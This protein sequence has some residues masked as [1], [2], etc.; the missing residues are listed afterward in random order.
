MP[1]FKTSIIDIKEV[2]MA[3][4]L[5]LFT[6]G[7]KITANDTN[8]NNRYLEN[9]A[10]DTAG[11]LQ[12]YIDSKLSTISNTLTNSIT[13]LSNSVVKLSGTQTIT[14]KKTFSVA[15]Y[16]TASDATNSIL[17]TVDKSKS[18]NGYLKLGNGIWLQWGSGKMQYNDTTITFPK[19]FPNAARVC[20]TKCNDSTRRTE[21]WWVRK[22]T[23]T[24]FVVRSS[25]T[26]GFQ[27]I[28]IGY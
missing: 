25:E 7:E 9:L 16:G 1:D 2:F 15:A 8:D 20:I 24:Y 18:G 19:P 21:D 23:T 6:A 22:V 27:W 4:E 13:S 12:A 10:S 26:D 3:D 17:T 11:T 14:G 28:A 5:K